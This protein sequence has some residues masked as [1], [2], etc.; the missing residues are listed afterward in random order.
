MTPQATIRRGEL[1]VIP[2]PQ[3][4]APHLHLERARDHEGGSKTNWCIDYWREDCP[5]RGW[6]WRDLKE[7]N[8]PP[9]GQNTQK[10]RQKQK[11]S[12][13]FRP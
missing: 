8:K 6:W 13:T 4:E 2:R 11:I 12:C 7:G 5:G 9:G 10:R 3:L 1:D